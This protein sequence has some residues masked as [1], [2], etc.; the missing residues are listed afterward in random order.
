MRSATRRL[1]VDGGA[2][3]G[4]GTIV[5]GHLPGEDQRTRP[6]ARRRQATFDDELIETDAGH[7][8]SGLIELSALGSGYAARHCSQ[9]DRFTIHLPIAS[10]R[11]SSMAAAPSAASARSRHSAAMR[12]DASR[13][14]RAG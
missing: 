11:S 9:F 10:S 4:G 5:D 3:L 13:P 6:L 8:G 12:R 2:R 14:Y 1:I 7:G